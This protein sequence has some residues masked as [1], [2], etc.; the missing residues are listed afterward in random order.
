MFL[1]QLPGAHSFTWTQTHQFA[2][3]C[4]PD[5]SG[6]RS[7]ICHGLLSHFRRG[8]S[9][10]GSS[11]F[12]LL[13]QLDHCLRPARVRHI[14]KSFLPFLDKIHIVK[15]MSVLNVKSSIIK[16]TFC[17]DGQKRAVSICLVIGFG[18]NKICNLNETNNKPGT[19]FN[20]IWC[21]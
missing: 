11:C 14:V 4:C 2:V 7:C 16:F 17:L 12:R 8:S 15:S 18:L 21:T 1:L 20:Y 5:E 19:M 10:W 6:V 9:H 3:W 13:L